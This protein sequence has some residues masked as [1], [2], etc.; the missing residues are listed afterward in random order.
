MTIRGDG[1]YTDTFNF[2]GGTMDKITILNKPSETSSVVINEYRDRI[3]STLGIVLG[4]CDWSMLTTSLN[5]A[6]TQFT[7]AL[8]GHTFLTVNFLDSSADIQHVF[9]SANYAQGLSTSRSLLI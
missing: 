9:L 7:A 8:A 4:G 5:S 3:N 6:S 1:E 2:Y